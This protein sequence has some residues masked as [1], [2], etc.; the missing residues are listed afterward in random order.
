MCRKVRV[1][2]SKTQQRERKIEAVIAVSPA[3]DAQIRA[4]KDDGNVLYEE[5]IY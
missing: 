5:P 1:G 3:G 2:R 4:L